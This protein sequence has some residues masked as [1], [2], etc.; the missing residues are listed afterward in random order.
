MSARHFRRRRDPESSPASRRIPKSLRGLPC[1]G[2]AAYQLSPL[3][4][5]ISALFALEARTTAP[6]AR[7]SISLYPPRGAHVASPSHPAVPRVPVVGPMPDKQ[8]CDRASLAGNSLHP[9][10]GHH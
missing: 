10:H 3:L 5:G 6:S 2:T 7:D 4:Q 9:L 1:Y 8:R